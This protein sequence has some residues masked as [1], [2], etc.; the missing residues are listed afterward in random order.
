MTKNGYKGYVFSR[1]VRGSFT[2]QRVQNLVIRDYVKRKSKNFLLSAVEYNIDNCFLMLDA[3][4][5]DHK[6]VEAL[7]FYSTHHL[8]TEVSH[9]H[10]VLIQLLDHQVE[11]HFALEEIIL[12]NISDLLTI[13]DIIMTRALS[14]SISDLNEE[15][16]SLLLN[17]KSDSL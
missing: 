4:V 14:K 17:K 16:S 6:E 5:A 12:K 8:P 7:V 3:L 11:I 1:S 15:I 10:R 13:E 2:P 9:R